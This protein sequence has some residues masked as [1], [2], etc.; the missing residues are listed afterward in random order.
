MPVTRSVDTLGDGRVK[1]A[2]SSIVVLYYCIYVDWL[3]AIYKKCSFLELIVFYY[4]SD[5]NNIKTPPTIFELHT[6]HF[7]VLLIDR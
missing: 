4:N 1:V 3:E 6:Y 5:I 7:I 2:R